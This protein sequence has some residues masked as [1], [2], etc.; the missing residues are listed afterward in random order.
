[1]KAIPDLPGNLEAA[2]QKYPESARVFYG[3]S[4]AEQKEVIWRARE[5]PSALALHEYV[6]HLGDCPLP[7]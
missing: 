4:E 6:R 5:M 7:S 1:M 3:F 2:L